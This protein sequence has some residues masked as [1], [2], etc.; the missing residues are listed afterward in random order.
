M[1]RIELLRQR[2]MVGLLWAA[3][4]AV[5]ALS[6]VPG[7]A[8]AQIFVTKQG[9]NTIGK[10]DVNTGATI[11]AALVTGV[12]SP[13]GIAVSG[14]TLFVAST[15][16]GTIGEYDAVTGAAINAA[17]ISGLD[18]V[19]GVAVSGSNLFVAYGANNGTGKIGEF[20]TTGAT[21]NASLVTG[22]EYPVFIAVSGSNL[23]VAD[24]GFGRISEYT[25]AGATVNA[26]LVSGFV[27]GPWGIAVSG[28]N[29]FATDESNGGSVGEF[30]ATTGAAINRQFVTGLGD[31]NGIAVFGGNLFVA[32]GLGGTIGEYDASTGATVSAALVSG[33]TNLPQG[34]AVVPEPRSLMLA[35]L[36]FGGF[37]AWGWRRA[38][39]VARNYSISTLAGIRSVTTRLPRVGT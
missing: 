31:T 35:V 34:I 18:Q 3:V 6:E 1:R 27:S 39:H 12:S 16:Q 37:A 23:Y 22:L 38:R 25:T 9:G 15:S 4:V 11:S 21:V 20:T 28:G 29:L 8:R 17:L 5:A 32:N 26:S 36:G 13:W 7:T 14:S 30:N 33:L 19:K 24:Y 2:T 10:Y